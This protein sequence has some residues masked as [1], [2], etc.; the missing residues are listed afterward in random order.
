MTPRVRTD[1]STHN[2]TQQCMKRQHCVCELASVLYGCNAQILYPVLQ[3]KL[4][5]VAR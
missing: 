3:C 4:V 1:G 2:T 5:D